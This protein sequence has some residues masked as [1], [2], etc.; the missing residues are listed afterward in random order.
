MNI[1]LHTPPLNIIS[2]IKR[3]P[4]TCIL[5]FILF[6]QFLLISVCNIKLIDN[7]IDVDT[8]KLFLH[9]KRMWEDR[10]YLIP[11]WS[12][13][14]TLELDCP[15]ILAVPL[16]A[17]L[18]NIYLAYGITNIIFLAAIISLVF[19]LFRG[20]EVMYPL[21]AC[22]LLCIPYS[23]GMLDYFNMM[24]FSGSQYFIRV[25]LPLFLVALILWVEQN[26]GRRKYFYE[27]IPIVL[28]NLLILLCTT[29]SG[30][31]VLFIGIFPIFVT[32]IL[33]K[34]L[35]SEKVPPLAWLLFGLCLAFSGIGIRLNGIF[36]QNSR[37]TGM[38][39]IS[40]YQDLNNI[41]SC[42]VG[43]FE[44][45]GGI[46]H[47]MELPILSLEG[48]CIIL[49]AILVHIF[50]IC[51]IVSI[52]RIVKKKFD[53][54]ILLLMS[55]FLWNLFA[56]LATN[57]RAGSETYEYRY[58]LIGMIPL[59]FVAVQILLDAWFR[60]TIFQK[61]FFA[62]AGLCFITAISALSFAEAL[63]PTDEHAELK[64]LCSYCDDYDYNYV[65]LYDAVGDSELC[66]LFT[67][68]SAEYLSV[69]TSGVT[70]IYDY[71]EKYI[72]KPICP[73]NSILV[74]NETSYN[75]G[76]SFEACGYQFIRFDTVA[77]RS[78]YYF[79]Q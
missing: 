54:R 24:F 39:L 20:K 9:T 62:A 68:S 22:N 6:I 74:V 35:T 32:Y 23:I 1:K 76:D 31:Y 50:I 2:Y 11:N 79:A 43:I 42:L 57:T 45:F 25:V 48:I 38:I 37:N 36:L 21:L 78:L 65:Y 71:Y 61:N 60:L 28:F 59:M 34:V 47:D 75:F 67:E 70:W 33:Y 41:Y 29:S 77:N 18:H 64:A 63:D 10:T 51:G 58:H 4:W 56:L 53:L 12:Y 72:N 19:F 3:H 8:A 66:R 30:I 46:A 49:K 15:A 73:E 52:V 16:Y 27:Y 69:T 14:S 55:I 7:N 40:V 44:L 5:A 26:S 17:L 13:P